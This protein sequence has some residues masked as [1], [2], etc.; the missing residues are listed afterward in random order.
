MP[1]PFDTEIRFVT[2]ETPKADGGIN[3]SA[4]ALHFRRVEET[5][6]FEIFK[7]GPAVSLSQE[8]RFYREVGVNPTHR[9]FRVTAPV[10]QE[11]DD[12]LEQIV[13]PPDPKK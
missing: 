3:H 10:W 13:T 6:K 8:S 5:G 4:L 9:S 2:R 11:M 12:L 7:A 1:G